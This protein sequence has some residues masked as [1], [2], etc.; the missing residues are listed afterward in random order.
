MDA[1][2]ETFYL[3]TQ[4]IIA[5]VVNFAIVAIVL[6]WAAVKP[7]LRV[8]TE[9]TKTIE[10]GLAHAEQAQVRLEQAGAAYESALEQARREADNLLAA[11][12][13]KAEQER[14][15]TMAK[16]KREVER[17][18]KTGK[19]QLATEKVNMISSAQRELLDLVLAVVHQV[20]GEGMSKDIDRKVIDR[21]LR[22]FGATQSRK[23]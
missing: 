16:T 3:D 18:V 4:L 19:E 20:L 10:D 14:T 12:G 11:A 21:A 15:A 13:A 7:L 17:I 9:R 23:K 6:W 22:S 8:M 1:L 2:I 5:Q